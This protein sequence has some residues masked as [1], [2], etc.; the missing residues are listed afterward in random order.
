MRTRGLLLVAAAGALALGVA[1]PASADATGASAATVTVTGGAL[2]ITVPPDA[3]NLGTRADTVG[4]GTISR[5]SRSVRRGT[6]VVPIQMGGSRPR[7]R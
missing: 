6:V 2:S 4:G 1:L 7:R 3:G 5:W